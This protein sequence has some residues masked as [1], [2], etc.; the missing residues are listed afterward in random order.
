MKEPWDNSVECSKM[1]V[2]TNVHD[3]EWSGQPSVVSDDLVQSEGQHFKISELLCEFPKISRIFLYDIITARLGYHN[4]W[5]RWVP[6]ML[7]GMH[8]THRMASAFVD[9]FRLIPPRWQWISQLRHT[10]KGDETWVSFVNV[11][12]KEQSKWWLHTR[13]P[14][15]PKNFK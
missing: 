3:E 11:T 5:A 8:K 7:M 1:G 9:F 15:K 12:T 10:S 2:Q 6:E 14:D 13:S 4:F